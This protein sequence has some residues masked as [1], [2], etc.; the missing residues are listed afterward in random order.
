M[1][2]PLVLAVTSFGENRWESHRYNYSYTPAD[3]PGESRV[4]FPI[5]W[6]I[7]SASNLILAWQRIYEPA[8]SNPILPILQEAMESGFNTAV[9]RSELG[10]MW[11]PEQPGEFGDK[12]F[13]LAGGHGVLTG[14][15]I[16][17]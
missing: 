12:F 2:V 5:A 1:A 3:S 7:R 8:Q 4:I 16:L 10:D 6:D 14:K 9:V 15:C 17:W 13:P 11:F